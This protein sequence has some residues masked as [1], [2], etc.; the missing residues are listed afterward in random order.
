MTLAKPFNHKRAKFAGEVYG[1]PGVR[2][3]L[4]GQLYNDNYEA[5]DEYGNRVPMEAASAPAPAAKKPAASAKPV[6]VDPEDETNDEPDDLDLKAW[7]DGALKVPFFTV[8]AAIASKFGKTATT[9][10]EAMKILR[11][12]SVI[13]E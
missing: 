6:Q 7:A 11:L 4:D 10:D 8:K 9:K 12:H 13:T 2:W 3:D 1:A 5:V